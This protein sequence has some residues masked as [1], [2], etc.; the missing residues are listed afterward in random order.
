MT[1]TKK[2]DVQEM[3][4]NDT[5]WIRENEQYLDQVLVTGYAAPGRW[6]TVAMEPLAGGAYR[7]ITGWPATQREIVAY[8]EEGR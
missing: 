1:T 7:P 3:V 4:D 2:R 8:I 6:I 5:Y